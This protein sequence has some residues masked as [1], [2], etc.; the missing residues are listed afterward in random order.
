MA[1]HAPLLRK[2]GARRR[3]HYTGAVPPRRPLPVLLLLACAACGDPPRVEVVTRVGDAP[4]TARPDG[5]IARAL[6]LRAD[7][8]RELADPAIEAML[9]DVPADDA[10]ARPRRP[11]RLPRAEPDATPDAAEAP[12]EA[13]EPAAD[14]LAGVLAGLRGMSSGTGPEGQTTIEAPT[15]AESFAALVAAARAAPMDGLAALADALGRTPASLWPQ[16][17]AELLADR[18]A[19][20]AD[21]KALLGLIGGDVPNRYG[22]FELGWK[23]AHGYAVKLSEDWYADL[24]ALPSARVSKIF[25]GIHRDCVVTAALLRAAAEIGRDPARTESVVDALLAAAY[26]HEGTFRD[27]VGRAIRRLGEPAIPGLL[28]RSQTPPLPVDEKEAAEIKAGV[29]YRKAEYARVQLDRMD[30]LQPRK[31]IA[32]VRD[33]PRLLADLLAAYGVTRPEEAAAPLLEHVDAAI[34][35]VRA[36]A[37]EAFLAFVSGPPPRAERKTL[38]LLGGHTTEAPARLT[39]RDFARLAIRER[40]GAEHPDLLEPECKP[41][42]PSGLR[43]RECEGQ[44]ARLAAAYFE[45]VELTRRKREQAQV[46]AALARTDR[47]ETVAMLDALLADNPELGMRDQ[48]VPSYEA[49]AAEAEA[50]GD[51]PRAAGLLRKSAAL[52][53]DADPERG[54]Q[55]RLR[56]LLV[57]A[58]IEALPPQGRAML[59]ATAQTLAPDDPAVLAAQER[60]AER[61]ATAEEAA[62]RRRAGQVGLTLLAGLAALMLLGHLLR[63]LW[64][65]RA[66]RPT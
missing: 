50:A 42:L 44:P 3:V 21:Y 30:R 5:L 43:D 18:K 12:S 34:P 16:V 47:A 29:A 22:H 64:S 54:K 4:A 23:R 6:K 2:F 7:R 25:R 31:A 33:D 35:R 46:D 26:V 9:G 19:R 17:E 60:V 20:K 13:A 39:H 56:A 15:S 49:A 58:E 61:P 63:A 28:R 36:A 59:L 11:R 55:L 10:P 66:A 53:A 14:P 48:L 45:R 24:L 51:L 41:V 38:R 40:V 52:L 1:A 32:A 57:E 62:L 27:E 37:R 65:R 8:E